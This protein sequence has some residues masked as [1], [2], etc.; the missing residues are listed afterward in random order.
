MKMIP[1]YN[2]LIRSDHVFGVTFLPS[3]PQSIFSLLKQF[4][5]YILFEIQQNIV[6]LNLIYLNTHVSLKTQQNFIY[7]K[8]NQSQPSPM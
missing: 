3:I 4:K 6:I 7:L 1:Q 5:G 2:T 8:F